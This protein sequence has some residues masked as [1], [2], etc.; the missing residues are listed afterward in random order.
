MRTILIILLIITSFMT[1]AIIGAGSHGNITMENKET[2]N[3]VYSGILFF[4]TA[5]FNG[6]YLKTKFSKVIGIITLPMN[7]VCAIILL[8]FFFGMFN[9]SLRKEIDLIVMTI[10]IG[11]EILLIFKLMLSDL[12]ELNKNWL[13]HRV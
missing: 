12:K 5:I 6:V 3:L 11:I 7:L 8:I 10:I 13:Q 9:P 1:F 4:L 2:A